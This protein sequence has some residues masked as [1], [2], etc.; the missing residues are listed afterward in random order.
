MGEV[1]YNASHHAGP[2]AEARIANRLRNSGGDDAD[3]CVQTGDSAQR[4]F[5]NLHLSGSAGKHG[6]ASAGR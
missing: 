2:D 4:V 6:K 5:H 3:V 1:K